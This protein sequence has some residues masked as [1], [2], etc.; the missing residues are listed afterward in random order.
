LITFDCAK[1]GRKLRV[2]DQFAGKN[3]RCPSCSTIVPVPQI[4]QPVSPSSTSAPGSSSSP[5]SSSPWGGSASQPVANNSSATG[6][7]GFW[8]SLGVPSSNPGNSQPAPHNPYAAVPT[9]MHSPYTYSPQQSGYSPS[10]NDNPLGLILGIL[11]VVVALMS[12]GCYGLISPVGLVLGIIAWASSSRER[13]KIAQGLARP[14]GIVESGYIL[15][16]IGTIL[17]AIIMLLFAVVIIGLVIHAANNPG[18][19]F[20]DF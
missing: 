17:S 1:C 14:S 10:T 15:G 4:G 7:Q 20:D 8:E 6:N 5:S 16:I 12:C 9:P 18:Q 2:A 13:T 3:C 19:A 11:S